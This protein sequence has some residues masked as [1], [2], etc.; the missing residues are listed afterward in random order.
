MDLLLL[1][2]RVSP[3]DVLAVR[4]ILVVLRIP[5]VSINFASKVL[6]VQNSFPQRRADDTF[7]Y[8]QYR[9]LEIIGSNGTP[10]KPYD[11]VYRKP[12]FYN[13]PKKTCIYRST[14]YIYEIEFS[15]SDRRTIVYDK[16]YDFT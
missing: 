15:Q 4:L 12:M 3:S 8:C 6:K 10:H 14:Y 13:K 16:V 9:Y 7:L 5:I 2:K 11:P 1:T